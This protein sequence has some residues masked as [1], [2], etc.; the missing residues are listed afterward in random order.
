M[1]IGRWER[2]PVII[3]AIDSY[4]PILLIFLIFYKILTTYS[5]HWLWW[6]SCMLF[7]SPCRSG[8][9]A[10]HWYHWS[11]C[12][13]HPAVLMDSESSRDIELSLR[14]PRRHRLAR[15]KRTNALLLG[16]RHPPILCQRESGRP[17][18][19]KGAT[20]SREPPLFWP[21]CDVGHLWMCWVNSEKN[22]FLNLTTNFDEKFCLLLILINKIKKDDSCNFKV[23]YN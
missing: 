5:N 20:S 21:L 22:S 6:H 10:T 8:L 18:R 16:G 3:D 12:F 4:V 23:W 2:Y 14:G 7:Y 1:Q 11:A 15:P 9:A 13:H 17:R 19:W